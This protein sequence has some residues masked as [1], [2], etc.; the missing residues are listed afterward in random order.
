[1]RR[2]AAGVSRL[3]AE[4]DA[5]PLAPPGAGRGSNGGPRAWVPHD[6]AGRGPG[7]PGWPARAV[8]G[9][10]AQ[11]PPG[12][13]PPRAVSAVLRRE[14]SRRQD[15]VSPVPVDASGDDAADR[16]V[17]LAPPSRSGMSGLSGVGSIRSGQIRARVPF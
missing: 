10:G 17:T 13:P 5:A 11:L 9:A 7:P 14:R 6:D 8:P 15:R 2:T 16:K 3:G 12:A 1:S 4:L